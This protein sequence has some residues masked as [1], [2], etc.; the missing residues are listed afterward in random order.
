MTMQQQ[1][2]ASSSADVSGLLRGATTV[3]GLIVTLQIGSQLCG[4]PV[5]AVR[6]VLDT[7]VITR[8]PLAA[9]EIA[10]NLNLRGRIVTAIDLR[11]RL[12]LTQATSG[13][14]MSVVTE[15]GSELYALLVDRVL[16]V[17]SIAGRVLTPLPPT[18]PV[19]WSRFG[20]GVYQLPEGL[21]I[22]LDVD[23]L[24]TLTPRAAR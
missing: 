14:G 3:S 20:S 9:D 21:L 10:G 18:L 16:E 17:V 15:H 13:A 11:V 22:M 24:L 12:G 23:R 5:R 4:L 7:Q 2:L 8:V 1:G 6:D 19:G